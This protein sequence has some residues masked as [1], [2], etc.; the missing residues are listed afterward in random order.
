MPKL[1]KRAVDA[2]KPDHTDRLIFDDEIPRFGLRIMRSGI[3]SYIIQYR[4][5]GHTRRYTFGKH[6]PIT[7]DE[8]RTRARQLLAA[9]DRGEDPS[10]ARQERRAAP[11]V[12]ELCARF[13]SEYVPHRCKPS[14]QREYRRSV[15][16]FIV[17]K[18][19]SLKAVDVQRRH[20]SDVHYQLRDIPYQANRTLGVLSKLFNL[21]EVWDVRSD[22]SNPCRHVEKYKEEKRERF[23]SGAELARL[24]RILT[25][26]EQTGAESPSVIAALRLLLL[27]GCRLGEIQTL[28]WDYVQGSVLLLP[29]SK[30]GAK[31]VAIGQAVLDVLAR[32]PQQP[33]NSYVITG[34]RPG[35]HLTDLERPWR[36]IRT[37]AALPDVRIH[38]LRH[39]FASSAV[40]L[41]VSLPMIGKLLG[42]NQVQTTARYAHL[43][44]EPVRSAA[45]RISAEIA[46]AL[47]HG[48]LAA[49][50]TSAAIG[51]AAS[52]IGAIAEYLLPERLEPAQ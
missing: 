45:D 3:K 19:G 1:T 31:S 46:H 41:G 37:R 32:I 13:L 22:G 12:A 35:S 14:T 48:P 38:D 6:G 17:P 11:T 50:P 25:E 24:G 33:G 8:A 52:S 44:H 27:T 9:V 2:L 34:K 47:S 20:I 49:N 15:E 18:L 39:S 4:S 10:L 40:G 42:H 36:R 28:K 21:A 29:D 5:D 7:P 43:A 16:L 51:E 26:A 30:T 23:L